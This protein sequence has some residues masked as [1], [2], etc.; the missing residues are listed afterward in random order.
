VTSIGAEPLIVWGWV[1]GHLSTI[2]DRVLE[3]VMLTA[4]AVAFGVL[5]SFPLGVAVDRYRRLYAPVTWVAGLLYTVPSIALFVL[6]IPFTGLG[7]LT[8]E[9]GLVSYTLLIL[10]RNVAT[11]I[12]GVPS[13]VK[14][15]ARGMGLTERQM[16]WRV[17]VPLALPVIVAGIRVATVSTIG[18]VTVGALI[19][20]GGLGQFILDGLQI[21][22]YTQIVLGAVLS[23]VL[24]LAAEA[25]LLW[26][27]RRLTPWSQRLAVGP[28][29]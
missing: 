26:A 2:G 25:V 27:Q 17:E 12:A 20:K 16:L 10:I 3:H 29:R 14:D 7:T 28:V 8:V 23:V 9:I 22:F 18:L 13:D 11:G 6:L 19:G 4:I 15:A 24:A 21:F 5:I 1:F